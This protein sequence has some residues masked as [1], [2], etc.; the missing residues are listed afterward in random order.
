MSD[1]VSNL[2]DDELIRMVEENDFDS[3]ETDSANEAT[4]EEN[5]EATSEDIDGCIDDDE[6]ADEGEELW[7]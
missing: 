3:S 6:Y 7:F 4:G 1:P 5:I 2:T